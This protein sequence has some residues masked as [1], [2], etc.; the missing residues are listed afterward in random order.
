MA[1][2][3]V[4]IVVAGAVALILSRK[5]QGDIVKIDVRFVVTIQS[6]CGT[7]YSLIVLC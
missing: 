1:G 5:G 4:L 2:F 6:P 3:A 7:A